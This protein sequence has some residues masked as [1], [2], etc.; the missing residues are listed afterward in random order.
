MPK[1]QNLW[2]FIA[3]CGQHSGTK[4]TRNSG[5][6][7]GSLQS[8]K[9][10]FGV[11]SK[12]LLVCERT[13]HVALYLL[14]WLLLNQAHFANFGSFHVELLC[15]KNL[16]GQK[17]K[18]MQNDFLLCRQIHHFP[19]TAPPHGTRPWR[20]WSIKDQQCPLCW[21]LSK[22]IL[23][24]RVGENTWVFQ[25]KAMNLNRQ[26]VSFEAVW[27]VN[28]NWRSCSQRPWVLFRSIIRF[29]KLQLSEQCSVK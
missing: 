12:S 2:C 20:T 27:K 28:V 25:N 7:V 17:Q 5:G 11:C 8:Q 10:S 9:L 24:P 22:R 26:T 6:P 29:C 4:D 16:L 14:V 1:P 18:R 3:L 23:D 15:L 13:Q 21:L 19:D